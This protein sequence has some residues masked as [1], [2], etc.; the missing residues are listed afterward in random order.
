MK[1][2]DYIAHK[3]AHPAGKNPS[4][5]CMAKASC[6]HTS[7]TPVNVTSPRCFRYTVVERLQIYADLRRRNAVRVRCTSIG[8]WGWRREGSRFQTEA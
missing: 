1:G 4:I 8:V 2:A 7:N 5:I 6:G 3:A